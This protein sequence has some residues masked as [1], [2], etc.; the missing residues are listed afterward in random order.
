MATE[1]VFR[2]I[3]M[4]LPRP[5]HVV[6][7]LQLQHPKEQIPTVEPLLVQVGVLP[8]ELEQ[9]AGWEA[10]LELA[11]NKPIAVG[12]AGVVGPLALLRHIAGVVTSAI[13]ERE[14]RIVASGYVYEYKPA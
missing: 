4:A 9:L 6:A 1:T 12:A 8:E 13:G 10:K 7:M 14:V 5:P 3:V 11:L 2:T